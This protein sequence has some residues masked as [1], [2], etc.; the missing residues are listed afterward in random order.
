[1]RAGDLVIAR[2]CEIFLGPVDDGAASL[3]NLSFST[4]GS[5]WAELVRSCLNLRTIP[6][7]VNIFRMRIDAHQHFWHYNPEE[8]GW[9][10]ERMSGLRCDFLP[11]DLQPELER[12]GF[13]GSIAVQAQQTIEETRWLL[14][15]AAA[16]P[17]ILGVVGWVDL[18][19]DN[20]RS[21]LEEFSG[22]PKLLG[23][24]HVL[25]SEPD[26]GF[27]LRP[28]FLRGVAALEE[29]GLTYDILIYPRHLPVAAEFV[30]QFPRQR[31][32]LDH[33][34]KPFI[35]RGQIEPWR[36]DLRRLAKF[37]NV[38]CKL[39]GMVTEADW[40][41][42]TAE[43]IA[44]YIKVTIECFGAERL[45]IGSDWPVCTVAGSYSRIMNLVLD[46]LSRHTDR[47]RE[48]ILGGTAAKL[49]RLR[50]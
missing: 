27:M 6:I 42:W 12:A 26:Y 14:E 22:N 46:F 17:F 3:R 24:R 34:A 38:Y 13:D 30:K 16:S 15:L 41:A 31:F 37:P 35:K 8:Y 40:G 39:S 48:A 21:Q 47:E 18:Q 50:R 29:F 36:S 19:S 1:M 28:E 7:S 20:V 9:I 23:V 5:A 44:P 2:R 25:Q 32:V 4:K 11:S 45:M 10:D 49:W 43:Q 33:L